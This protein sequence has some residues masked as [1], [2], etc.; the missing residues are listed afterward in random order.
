MCENQFYPIQPSLYWALQLLFVSLPIMI[1]MVY[2][3]HKREKVAIARKIKHASWEE[4]T[5]KKK[6]Q[7][8]EM[9]EKI[10]ADRA[11]LMKKKEAVM[12]ENPYGV[13]SQLTLLFN[14][15]KIH[16]NSNVDTLPK[17][18]NS[19]PSKLSIY[20]MPR[21][22]ASKKPRSNSKRT[23]RWR[24]HMMTKMVKIGQ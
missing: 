9:K 11:S 12:Y 13:V 8:D 23:M 3:S 19:R 6:A 7:F 18:K 21:N 2:V 1:F 10:Q 14:R 20:L 24:M 15:H 17:A 4:H 16:K 5:K 22:G